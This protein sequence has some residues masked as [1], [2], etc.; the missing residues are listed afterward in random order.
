MGQGS[1]R[2][3]RA[4]GYTCT[5]YYRDL[6]L[7]SCQSWL[8]SLFEA[9]ICYFCVSCWKLK[10]GRQVVKEGERTWGG[11]K[12]KLELETSNWNPWKRTRPYSGLSLFS[13]FPSFRGV[14]QRYC[15]LSCCPLTSWASALER[16]CVSCRSI[17]GSALTCKH[18]MWDACCLI[19]TQLLYSWDKR[20]LGSWQ[21]CQ[22][23]E[24]HSHY[25]S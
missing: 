15:I 24:R 11:S 10:S 12:E 2:K 21:M 6:T 18:K 13:K 3:S 23:L 19:L 1:N 17:L 25:R 20:L 16:R 7:C 4:L 9:G 22:C 14:L 8:C 5:I